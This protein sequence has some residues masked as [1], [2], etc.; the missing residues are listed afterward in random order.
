MKFAVVYDSEEQASFIPRVIDILY[1]VAGAEVFTITSEDIMTGALN[2]FDAVVFP[3]GVASW[4]GLRRWG[5][6]F[7]HAIRYFVAAGGGYLGVCGGAYI[8]GKEAPKLI[9]IASNRTLMLVDVSTRPPPIIGTFKEYMEQQWHRFPIT[10]IITEIYHPI[11]AGHLGETVEIAYSGGAFMTNP[12]EETIPLA[13]FENGEVAVIATNFGQGR[14]VLCS[15]HPEAPW[16]GDVGEPSLPWLY[17]AMASWVAAP[18][19]HPDYSPLTPWQ[20]PAL[21]P[22]ALPIAIGAI[23]LGTGVVIGR[24][25]K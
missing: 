13:F 22:S 20:R 25:S 24:K 23:A 1:E 10:V 18:Q 7:G 21:I 3:G 6:N 12:G 15:P 17:P 11:I 9:N 8:A 14:V 16:E 5:A 2:G 4:T 19:L